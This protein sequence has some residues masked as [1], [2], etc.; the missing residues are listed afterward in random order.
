LDAILPHGVLYELRKL[1]YDIANSTNPSAMAALMD[2]VPPTQ[3]LFGSDMPYVPIAATAGGLDKM[4]IA[5][6]LR[7]AI[8]RDNALQ[9][10]PRLA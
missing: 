2:L 8:N 1:H 3:I 10:F 5:D 6:E 9:L 7:A 4:T